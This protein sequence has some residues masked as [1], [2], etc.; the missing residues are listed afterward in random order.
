MNTEQKAKAY[1]EA[2]ERA[3]RIKNGE[4]NWGY[5]DLTEIIPAITEI[6]PQLRESEDER[7]RKEIV[8]YITENKNIIPIG[9]PNHFD[10]MLIW[11]EKQKEQKP[12]N[13]NLTT[14]HRDVVYCAMCDKNLDEGLRCNLEVVYKTIKELV[15]RTP[16][17]PEQNPTSTEDM[18][19][20]ADE[21]FYEREPADSFK[22]KLAEY[23]TKSCRKEEGPDGYTYVISAET[24]LKMAEEELLKRG[25]V[26][27]PAETRQNPLVRMVEDKKA[28]TEDIRNGI[29]TKTIEKKRNVKFATPVD[30]SHAEWSEEDEDRIRQ[31]ERIAQQAGCTQ[32]LQEEIHDWLKSRRPQYHGDVTMTEAYKMGLE[33]GKAS[34]WKPSE[35]EKGA[36]RTAIHILTDERSFPKAAAQLQNILN[37]FEGTESRKD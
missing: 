23:M 8:K 31:I 36:L 35:L 18:P 11:L 21:H 12:V 9:S 7:I 4:D 26:Q 15:D 29:S 20:V 33:T 16:V 6:F 27:K 37:A 19:Y 10:K 32:K 30:V 13:H 1:D 14:W 2:L 25:V 28:I 5:C 34:S 22:Y 17:V 3:N 24:I